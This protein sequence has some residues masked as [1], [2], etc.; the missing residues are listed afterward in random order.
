MYAIYGIFMLFVESV[1]VYCYFYLSL[2]GAY[3][4]RRN[5]KNLY[6]TYK[7]KFVYT[8]IY[9]ILNLFDTIQKHN[10]VVKRAKNL[11]E[12][13]Y[14]FWYYSFWDLTKLFLRCWLRLFSLIIF[15]KSNN[16]SSL[17]I[18]QKSKNTYF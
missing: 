6:Y 14:S 3:L 1:A 13:W 10:L 8:F 9:N 5:T 16:Q 11:H 18:C 12:G 4:G 2:A 7:A 17:Y 15:G